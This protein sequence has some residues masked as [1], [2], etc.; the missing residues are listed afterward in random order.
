MSKQIRMSSRPK[1]NPHADSWV[2][3]SLPAAA[4]RAVKPKR[5]TIDIDPNLHTRLKLH[6]V[7]RDVR[8]ADL[9]RDLI[10]RS[11]SV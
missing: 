1:Q 7:Q 9:L 8:I 6:C 2:E 11:L 4:A 3:T 10:E 5:L